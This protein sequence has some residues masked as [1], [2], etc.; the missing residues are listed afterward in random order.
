MES[1]Y[2][3]PI[4]KEPVWQPEIPVYFFTG[5][6]GGASSVLSLVARVSGNELLARRSIY[7]GAAADA[8]SPL[9]LIS[10]LGRPERFLNMLRVFKVTS[11]MS[12]GSWILAVS[13]AGSS[14]AAFL[15]AIGRLRRV[16]DVA[17][18]V[19]AVSGAPLAVYT[20]TL[21]SDTAIPVW[22]EARHELPFLFGSSAAASAGAAAVIAVPTREAAPA[23]R[24]AIGGALVENAV[25]LAMKRRLGPLGE[26][27]QQDQAG[28]SAKVARACSLGGATLLALAGRRSRVASAAGGAL[29]L[30]GELALRWSVFKA[31]FQS[32][33]D[34][35]YT[36]RAQRERAA[37]RGAG[38]RSDLPA[39]P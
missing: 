3:R 2:G 27:Y 36:V 13:S 9:L 18:T 11:P 25:M 29:V 33:R 4:I 31:G 24:L 26:P 30:A 38:A 16:G 21:I 7:V 39:R 15:N 12:V 34:P 17:R 1:Y 20:A 5:G 22:H 14:G 35:K 32:A 28:R 23:R 19:S 6:L 8:V 10:D 37:R